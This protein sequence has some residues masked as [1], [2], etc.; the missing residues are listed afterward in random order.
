MY[1]LADLPRKGAALY[2]PR[3]AVVFEDHEAD[4]RRS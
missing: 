1:T 4:L 2:G 3:T